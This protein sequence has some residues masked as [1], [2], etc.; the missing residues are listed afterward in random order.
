MCLLFFSVAGSRSVLFGISCRLLGAKTCHVV[1]TTLWDR[2]RSPKTPP[3]GKS[4]YKKPTKA[5]GSP[6]FPQ[7]TDSKP[8]NES[9]DSRN[10]KPYTRRLRVFRVSWVLFRVF[11]VFRVFRIC[12]GFLVGLRFLGPEILF[13]PLQDLTPFEVEHFVQDLQDAF[14]AQKKKGT[15]LRSSYRI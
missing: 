13:V 9:L 8:L 4:H 2:F 14:G 11:R 10:P 3:P 12:C 7:P 15:W 5:E 1:K 6:P